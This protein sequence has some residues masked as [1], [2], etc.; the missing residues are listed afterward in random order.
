MRVAVR[1]V[2]LS[3]VT[4]M[5]AATA[6]PATA[7]AA[8]ANCE[9]TGVKGEMWP[10]VPS[11]VAPNLLPQLGGKATYTFGSAGTPNLSVCS[12]DGGDPQPVTISSAGD[13]LN[14]ICGSGRVFARDPSRTSIVAP[15]RTLYGMTY[16]ME[17]FGGVGYIDVIT[18]EGRPEA[19]PPAAVG[20]DV[21]GQVTM[22]PDQG[23]GAD[24][25]TRDFVRFRL[26]FTLSVTW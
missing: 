3:A 23:I 18:V 10:Y 17:I 19:R 8:T 7:P 2:A 1:L 20:W 6:V 26:D 11:A 16:M 24:C 12:I 15:T 13:F 25:V 5:A 4:F 9:L 21:D 22:R 14:D